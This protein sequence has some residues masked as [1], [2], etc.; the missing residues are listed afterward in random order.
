MFYVSS[1]KNDSLYGITDTRDGVEEFYTD[2]Q[3]VKFLTKDKLDIY[4][5]SYFNY[6]SNC[7][8]VSIDMD[9]NETKL[10]SLIQEWGKVHNQ[11]TG[12]KVEDY[13]A[14]SKIGTKIIV[15][16]VVHPDGG[17]RPVSATTV[18]K[19]LSYDEWLF[20]DTDNVASGER[21]NSRFAAWALEVAC[22]Y[23]KPRN[24]TVINGKN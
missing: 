23:S 10:K 19:R 15:D 14:S 9:L 4:G 20:E 1:I 6:K 13:L 22:L 18:I 12:H 17:G 16:Y 21:G 2:A 24:I 5:T 11:W 8:V 7:A 3:I